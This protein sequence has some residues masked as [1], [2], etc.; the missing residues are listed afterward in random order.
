MLVNSSNDVR[1]ALRPLIPTLRQLGVRR[2]GLFGSLARD[3]GRPDS[4]LDVLVE[5]TR[6]GHTYDNAFSVGEL[7][8]RAMG[9]RVELVTPESLSR[10]IGPHIL[11]EVRYVDLEPGISAPHS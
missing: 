4:D 11:S 8:E 6:D 10:Y 3:E 7:L 2:L 5:F 1:E 9:R